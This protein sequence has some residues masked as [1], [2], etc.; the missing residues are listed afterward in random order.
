MRP[1]N[2]KEF[3]YCMGEQVLAQTAQRGC[4][5]SLN[6]NIQ[7]ASGCNPVLCDLG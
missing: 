6:G 2:E 3:H 5:I 4:D 1:V 7:E